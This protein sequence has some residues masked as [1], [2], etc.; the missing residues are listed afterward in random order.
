MTSTVRRVAGALLILAACGAGA[1]GFV[2]GSTPADPSKSP[3]GF[4][5]TYSV[6]L[7]EVKD[8]LIPYIRR[9]RIAVQKQYG[10]A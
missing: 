9:V 6:L 10:C 5:R 8:H 1:T 2:V 3:T 7:A 4:N